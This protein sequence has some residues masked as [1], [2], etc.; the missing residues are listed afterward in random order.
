MFSNLFLGV[1][2]QVFHVAITYLSYLEI[3]EEKVEDERRV[4]VDLN[5]CDE[6]KLYGKVLFM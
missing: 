2:A 6:F 1:E 5:V 3:N 4:H